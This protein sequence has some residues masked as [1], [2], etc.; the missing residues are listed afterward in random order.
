MRFCVSLDHSGFM[1]SNCFV[2]FSFFSA[3][4]R[5]LLER[6]FPKWPILCRVGCETLLSLVLHLLYDVGRCWLQFRIRLELQ[7]VVGRRR[8]VQVLL[9]WTLRVR[10]KCV[11]TRVCFTAAWDALEKYFE[12]CYVK[13]L[14]PVLWRCWLGGRNGIRPVKNWVVGCWS[15]CLSGVR[16]RLAYS[17][18]NATATHC[19]LLQ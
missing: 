14:P 19:L 5:D 11:K 8:N 10:R 16:C 15:G 18:A 13:I 6:T 4:P 9:H 17:P 2:G 3:E 12:E 1:F 7:A